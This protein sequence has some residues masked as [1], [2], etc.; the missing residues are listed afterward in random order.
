MDE[1]TGINIIDLEYSKVI[2]HI[3][4]TIS[5]RQV[6][7]KEINTQCVQTERLYNIIQYQFK[8][9]KQYNLHHCEK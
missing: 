5:N 9:T 7:K 6:F 2:H 1:V 3:L 8:L 4:W